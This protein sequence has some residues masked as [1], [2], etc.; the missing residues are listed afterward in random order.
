VAAFVEADVAFAPFLNK[1]TDLLSL[2]LPRFVEEG[3]K[4]LGVAIGCTGGRHRSVH[5]VEALAKRLALIGAADGSPWR[6]TVTHRE[7][8]RSA[9]DSQGADPK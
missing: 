5:V 1:V 3:K 7:L 2:L 6:V 4:Y 9:D 8:S